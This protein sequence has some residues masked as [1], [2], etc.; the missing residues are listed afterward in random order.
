MIHTWHKRRHCKCPLIWM[1]ERRCSMG[2]RH[3]PDYTYRLKATCDVRS[4]KNN[5]SP[6]D[7]CKIQCPINSEDARSISNTPKLQP[8]CYHSMY[9]CRPIGYRHAQSFR[10]VEGSV[11]SPINCISVGCR[12]SQ[13][14]DGCRPIGYRHAQAFRSVEGSVRSPINRISVGCRHSPMSVKIG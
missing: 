12:Q 14:Y 9:W 2:H 10:S 3:T 4:T 11:R 5:A 6:S 8:H 7:A 13:M 1:L